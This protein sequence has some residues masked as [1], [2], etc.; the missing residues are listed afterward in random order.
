MGNRLRTAAPTGEIA[1]DM[2]DRLTP[3]D[4]SFLHLENASSPMHVA[5][6]MTFDGEP[7]LV[8][9]LAERVES[10]LHLVPRYRQKLASVPLAQGR[11]VWV[12]DEDFDINR[13]VRG[14]ALAPPGGPEELRALAGRLFSRQ[15]RRDRPMWEMYLVSGLAD[16]GGRSRFA[17]VSKTHHAVVDGISGLDVMSALFAPDDE[18]RDP[19]QWKPEPAPSP[20]GRLAGALMD[21]A[22][23]PTELIRPLR[24]IVR[25]PRR[26][27]EEVGGALVGAGA[28]AWAGLRPAPRTPYN[29]KLAGPDR[30]VA[31]LT[32]DLEDV[33]AIKNSLGGT[34]NDVVLAT[35]ARAL[36]RDLERRGNE[37]DTLHAFVPVSVRQPGDE[38]SQPGNEVSGMVVDLPLGCPDAIDCLHRITD[39]TKSMKESGQAVGAKALT[40]LSGFAPPTIVD[41]AMR[42]SARQ[43]FINLVITNVPGPQQPL[44]LDGRE[45]LEILPMVPIGQNLRICVAIVSYNGTMSFAVIAD[46]DLMPEPAAMTADIRAA[47]AELGEP[48]REVVREQQPAS[49]APIKD[50]PEKP[51]AAVAAA[52]D[53]RAHVDEGS[54]KVAEF[55]DPGAE[56]GAGA[57]LHVDEPWPN[58]RRMTAKEIVDRLEASDEAEIAVVRLYEATHR[59]RRDV[60]RAT[61]RVLKSV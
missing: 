36:R 19:S 4:A 34:V 41:V 52:D 57:E 2:P 15:L 10:R 40:D 61:E 9:E 26:V 31:W 54:E 42:L 56:N 46:A 8:G 33:K 21:R 22:T 58:Y 3:L 47:L 45:L 30:A 48:E 35:V 55:A 11:P 60:M 59:K 24:A 14:T 43:R 38:R 17:I 53:E 13:H 44:E 5:C 29:E 25:R 51:V 7:P 6:V 27:I 32:V 49:S 20:I 12:D 39:V 23:S 1:T 50:T 28:F 37:T 16:V 18:Y